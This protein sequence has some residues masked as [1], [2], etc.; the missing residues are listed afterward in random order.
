MH[1]ITFKKLSIKNGRNFREVTLPLQSVG[2]TSIL[3]VNGAGKSTIWAIL[4]AV[5]FG[6]TPASRKSFP[7]VKGDADASFMLELGIGS[8]EYVVSYNR[9][10]GKWKHEIIKNGTD[11]TPH[12][13]VEAAKKVKDIIGLD[14]GEFRGSVH[15]GQNAQ[16]VLI[17]GKPSDRKEYVSTFFGLD[18]R[19]DVVLEAASQQLKEVKIKISNISALSH[20][21]ML[22]EDELN[23]LHF[24]DTN[25]LDTRISEA[26][27]A[28]MRLDQNIAYVEK[29]RIDSVDYRKNSPLVMQYP[30]LDSLLNEVSTSVR[31]IQ[32]ELMSIS[33]KQQH[34]YRT[35]ALNKN[36]ND[37]QAEFDKLKIA[38]PDYENLIVNEA[39][40]NSEIINLG[41]HKTRYYQIKNFLDELDNL[42]KISKTELKDQS[43]KIKEIDATYRSTSSAFASSNF[44]FEET[45]NRINKFSSGFCPTCNHEVD[46]KNLEEDKKALEQLKA[47][48]VRLQKKLDKLLKDKDALEIV[49][50]TY[51]RAKFLKEAIGNVTIFDAGLEEELQRLTATSGNVKKIKA[52]IDFLNKNKK[53]DL[54]Q[55]PDEN[56]LNA[57]L[58]ILKEQ[59]SFFKNV[60]NIKSKLPK[61]PVRP[62]E[63]IINNLMELQDLR[64]STDFQLNNLRTELGTT[65]SNN[66]KYTKTKNQLLEIDNKVAEMHGLKQQEFL[67][68]KLVEAY[69]Q[70]GL[71]VKKLNEI[72]NVVMAK[73]PN[74][75]S[76]L[77]QEKGLTF[78]HNCDAGNI[79]IL[80]HR[81]EI[82][83]DGT[84]FKFEHDVAAF[85]GGENKRLSIAF[86]L[87]LADCVPFKKRTNLLV[88]DEL[89]SNLDSDG[90]YMFVNEL[91]PALKDRYDSVFI[92]SHAE[93]VNQAQVYDNVWKFKKKNH[94]SEICMEANCS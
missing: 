91:L 54:Y 8:D 12:E 47:D 80:A 5:I 22:L 63:A 43:E 86:V 30:N 23:T 70:K 58:S 69:G 15:L 84:I 50:K 64:E 53:Q 2:I 46:P 3:G 19:Y 48:S 67:F 59:E 41:N 73:L 29:E 81:E 21:K 94:R 55:I 75:V 74:Y 89:D 83:D 16:H 27:K 31:A 24:I 38:Y 6:T 92:I 76:L 44:A 71:R 37:A 66:Q 9:K 85:S 13:A 42:L 4:E 57:E 61:E 78:R 39:S 72:M 7:L 34:N 33:T 51:N 45:L 32:V 1:N 49:Q 28:L 20:S 79:D 17:S 56:K 11:E 65:V 90:Q 82:A 52:C 88:L 77:F 36:I 25:P 18:E 14:H 10:K 26:D 40:I 93:E 87:T 60:E 68:A 62:Y 35:H